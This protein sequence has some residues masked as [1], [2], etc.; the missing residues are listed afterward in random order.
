[1]GNPVSKF[2]DGRSAGALAA[3]VVVY[4]K[5]TEPPGDVDRSR[6]GH[7]P[8]QPHASQGN[9]RLLLDHHLYRPRLLRHQFGT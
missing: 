1:M 7:H 3:P 9:C 6:A 8:M 5:A 2:T 4:K